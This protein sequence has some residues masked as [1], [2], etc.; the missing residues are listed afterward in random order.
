MLR[1]VLVVGV[2]VTGC[3][4]V[5]SNEADGGEPRGFGGSSSTSGTCAS[6]QGGGAI[7]A[8]R[9]PEDYDVRSRS[10]EDTRTGTV[11][12]RFYSGPY[13]YESAERYCAE[14]TIDGQSGWRLPTR[15]ELIFLLDYTREY[16]PI[17]PGT[18][19]E[20]PSQ[21][22]DLFG[23]CFWTSTKSTSSGATGER[24]R[25]C[26]NAFSHVNPRTAA[27][28]E[29]YVRCVRGNPAPASLRV[30]CGGEVVIDDTHDLMWQR[31]APDLQRAQGGQKGQ[32]E[33]LALAGFD[34]WRLPSISELQT[35][36]WEQPG[37]NPT[38]HPDMFPDAIADYYW[39]STPT[40][41]TAP[42]GWAVQFGQAQGGGPFG[43][44]TTHGL[45]G[46]LLAR[47]VR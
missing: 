40:A 19:F 4:G 30:G 26:F 20:V 5:A 36:V 37:A 13:D 24:W 22:Q 41:G 23:G 7:D 28:Q 8:A 16:P 43:G 9:D 15:L 10:F 25:V 44:A 6:D 35:L 3:G 34:D 27:D 11:Y 47:C 18:T 31:H 42:N 2:V 29:L 38:L 39:S 21:D 14:Q 17:A 12:D 45:A 1:G 32:C 33:S 46:L